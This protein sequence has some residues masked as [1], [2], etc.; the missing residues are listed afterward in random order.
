LTE[1]AREYLERAGITVQRTRHGG[2]EHE[3]WKVVIA[4]RLRQ[5]GF[6][7]TEEHPIGDGKTVDLHATRDNE[8]LFVEI[9]TGRS[10]IIANAAKCVALGGTVLFVFTDAQVR[11]EH[12]ADIR[13][14]LPTARLFTTADLR[15]LP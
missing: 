10:D 1:Q 7:V 14:A 6:T 12:A 9:E 2:P 4:D 3:Y 5:Q 8:Q 15:E 13:A 11:D